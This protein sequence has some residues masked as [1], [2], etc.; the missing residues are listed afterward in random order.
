[1]I[2]HDLVVLS[3]WAKQWLITFNPTKKRRLYYLLSNIINNFRISNLMEIPLP[4]FHPK[5]HLGLTLSN[6]GRWQN[7]IE[8]IVKTAS[9]IIDIMR[10]I[11]YTFH[12][13]A[14]Y[15]IYISYVYLF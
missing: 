6:N 1:M 11:K 2:N 13:V 14:L 8:N 4:L 7:H 9:K 5:K 12:R 10:K 3:A 15:Q